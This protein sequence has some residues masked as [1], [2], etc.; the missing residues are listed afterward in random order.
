MSQIQLQ[1]KVCSLICCQL[2]KYN[3]NSQSPGNFYPRL[4]TPRHPNSLHLDAQ[5]G[6]F[7]R[8]ECECLAG[9]QLCTPMRIRSHDSITDNGRQMLTGSS[10]S[11]AGARPRK[12]QEL[13][14]AKKLQKASVPSV[15]LLLC[16]FQRTASCLQPLLSLEPENN[17]TVC[18]CNSKS[19]LKWKTNIFKIMLVLP[20][21]AE[22]ESCCQR[23][24]HVCRP[25]EL[26]SG[27]EPGLRLHINLEAVIK[28]F[29]KNFSSLF[30]SNEFDS[31][32][33]NDGDSCQ[34]S[35]E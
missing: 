31:Q 13:V 11:E 14:A 18:Y 32:E 5:L 10:S 3:L 24:Q 7:E 27:P 4:L 9:D 30:Y 8:Q 29:P 17:T 21:H 16:V 23:H 20:Q 33:Q 19:E 6:E 1:S 2:S 15:S 28:P 34:T 35:Q 26:R 25:T 12:A 22:E